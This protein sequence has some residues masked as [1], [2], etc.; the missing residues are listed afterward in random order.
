[1]REILAEL[2]RI[3]LRQFRSASESASISLEGLMLM[4]GRTGK[5]LTLLKIG[6][7]TSLP[8]EGGNASSWLA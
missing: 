4:F 3:N 7:I 2:V 8:L 5:V 1:M 6:L